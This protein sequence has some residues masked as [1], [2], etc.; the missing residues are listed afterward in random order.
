MLD[1][2]DFLTNCYGR[3][4]L[5]PLLQKMVADF[6]RTKKPFTVLILDVDHFKSFNDKYG[7][8]NGDEVLKYF[9]SSMRLDL[10]D[11]ENRP[12][13][14]GGDEF[15]MVFPSKTAGEA[16]HLAARLRR[17]IKTRS[18]LIKGKQI[19]ISFS[20][21]IASFPHDAKDVDELLEKA[22]KALYRAKREGRNRVCANIS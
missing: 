8:M 5:I 10:E 3:E 21:G 18:C 1:S 11:E 9:S 7:H 12:F 22:D 2:R 4:G 14:F 20:G 16:Y 6:P 17:N 13:R 19:A 15:I